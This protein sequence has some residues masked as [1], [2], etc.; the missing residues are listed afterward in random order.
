M[1]LV[2]HHAYSEAVLGLV[3]VYKGMYDLHVLSQLHYGQFVLCIHSRK[4]KCNELP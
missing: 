2:G 3:L 4:D 1:V